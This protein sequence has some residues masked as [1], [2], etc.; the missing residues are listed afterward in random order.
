MSRGE[1]VQDRVRKALIEEPALAVGLSRV[2]FEGPYL[3]I[4]TRD[5]SAVTGENDLAVRIAKKAKKRVIVRP[6]S[7]IRKKLEDARRLF[8]E[9]VPKEAKV[10]SLHFN[11]LT[12]ELHVYALR[13]GSVI[14]RGGSTLWKLTHLIGW[15]IV[16]HRA[17]ASESQAVKEIAT[18]LREGNKERL[19]ALE[20]IGHRLNREK[21]YDTDWIRVTPL[22]GF[23][24]V[25]RS[26]I[27]VETP[28]SKILLDAGA[29]PGA[30]NLRDEYP[31]FYLPDLEPESIDAVII[32]HAHLDHS[33]ALP[34]LFKYGYRGP[35]YM[36]EATLHLT[37][38]LID[39]YLKVAE[40]EGRPLPY[41]R[42]DVITMLNHV[43]PLRYGEVVDISPD[44]KLALYNAGHILGSS[45]VHLHIG[46]GLHNIVY[47]G[48]FK[49]APTLLLDR[50]HNE[51]KRVET[52]IM[53]STYGGSRDVMPSREE[54]IAQ[55][56][57]I[58]KNTIEKGGKVLMPMLAVGRA[59]E[60]LLVLYEAFESG[61]LPKI[62][63]YIEGMIHET[64]AIHTAFLDELSRNVKEKVFKEG[65]MPFEVEYFIK[66]TEKVDRQEIVEGGPAIIIATS[67]MLTGGPAVE[68]LKLL[69]GDKKNTLIFTSY[70]VPGTLGRRVL[71]L[72]GVG[73]GG[74][75]VVVDGEVLRVV[76][77]VYS[78]EGF[79]GHSDRAQLINYIR[80]M[81]AKPR[82]VII[83][84]VEP[85]KSQELAQALR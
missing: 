17:P 3:V 32:S 53:E 60:I 50:A 38:I 44:I 14:G 52:L 68:Y 71:D 36:T 28:N 77:G 63:V 58:I 10:K 33:V 41:S 31:G 12:G 81:R 64:T 65:V 26:C 74:F 75:E 11:E 85:T 39:D 46:E 6:S 22:G 70:Q 47:T 42:G 79:S 82:L 29:K 13:P 61:Q 66:L 4:Y 1:T 34:Y 76:M 2:E 16:V 19:K 84:H 8:L 83:G 5:L 62:P 57:T 20:A 24:E 69:A 15:K 55:L 54:S 18:L 78:V 35:V 30:R 49:F 48:D 73:G 37:W 56:I 9:N 59:Q 51:F 7:E 40:R 43:I 25:G 21:I 80:Y 23:G 67:G 45:I 27:L 72:A